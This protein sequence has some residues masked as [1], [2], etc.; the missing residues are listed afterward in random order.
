MS[1]PKT[2]LVIED[3]KNQRFLFEEDLTEAG[4]TVIACPDALKALVVLEDTHIDLILTD[5]KLPGG[6]ATA[7]IP[8]I[9]DAQLSIPVVVVSGYPAY[10]GYLQRNEPMVR[11]FFKKPVNLK[12][13]RKSIAEILQKQSVPQING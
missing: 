10:K 4:Y 2:I 3:E 5:I 11:A 9:R 1:D 6:D 12:D 7:F 13:L 8:R